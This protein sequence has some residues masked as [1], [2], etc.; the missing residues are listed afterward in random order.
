MIALFLAALTI[1]APSPSSA[2]LKEIKHVTT[3]AFCTAFAENVKNSVAGI[4]LNDDLFRRAEPAFAKIARDMNDSPAMSQFNPRGAADRG[5][6]PSVTLDMNRLRD[7]GASVV[8]NLQVIDSLLND[9][10]RFPSND[11]S[12]E[13]KELLALRARLMQVAKAQNDELNVMSGTAEEYMM[14]SLM[15]QDVSYGGALSANGKT[16]VSNG[17]FGGGL[18]PPSKPQSG[19]PQLMQDGLFMNSAIGAIYRDFVRMEAGEQQMELTFAAVLAQASKRC[20][21]SP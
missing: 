20:E 2:P 12:Q 1:A 21:P 13:M 8:H 9:A 6:D 15:G 19:D 5:E 11:S 16:P 14:D 7:L 17:V 18:L 10:Q 3:S 4:A